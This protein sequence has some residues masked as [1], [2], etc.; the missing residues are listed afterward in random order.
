MH[1]NV[2]VW[3]KN[4]SPIPKHL[5]GEE[6]H[7]IYNGLGYRV[8]NEWVIE[9]NAYGY[10]NN[11]ITPPSPRVD[12]VVV[13][14][15]HTNST[16]QGHINPTG[17][18]HT[19]GGTTGG[20]TP[21]IPGHMIVVHKEYVLDY[22]SPLKNV[23]IEAEHEDGILT[24]R[25]VYALEKEHVVITGMQNG[26]SAI[27]P[28]P[29]TDILKLYYHT[30]RLGSVDYM[31]D[32]IA[33]DIRGYV[34]YDDWGGLTAKTV[35]TSGGHRELFDL[36][37]QYT[38]HPYDQVLDLYFAQARMYDA[39]DRRFTAVDPVKGNI[40]APPSLNL[41]VYVWD[42]P[43]IFVD[44]FG[45]TPQRV[46]GATI[47]VTF[48]G[49]T[50]AINEVYAKNNIVY[51]DFFQALSAYGIT[52]VSREM[53][54]T[55]YNNNNK[56]TFTFDHVNNRASYDVIPGGVHGV[57]NN[58][59][60]TGEFYRYNYWWDSNVHE[61]HLVTLDYFR[62]LMCDIGI[63]SGISSLALYNPNRVEKLTTKE[64]YAIANGAGNIKLI[65]LNTKKSLFINGSFS[66]WGAH[67][68][69]S[70]KTEGGVAVVIN[71]LRATYGS[72]GDDVSVL[73]SSSAWDPRP[74]I[75]EVNGYRIA[76]GFHLR[77]HGIYVGGYTPPAPL[78][79]PPEGNGD[80]GKEPLGG[81]TLG[82]HMCMYYGDNKNRSAP[83]Y[84]DV[85][86][87]ALEMVNLIF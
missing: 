84:N 63:H 71:I 51:V 39:L 43:L 52:D 16:G 29:N 32:N 7:Y 59:G 37:L 27:L 79:N 23:L 14:D 49:L 15:R 36:V 58:L 17:K 20:T 8:A 47:D 45:F 85:V 80:N 1:I 69:W 50:K 83:K 55:I 64:V 70:P 5:N 56:A 31:T 67:T 18:G 33:G 68:D 19:T 87:K 57:W 53:S 13:C 86:D 77:P 24:Y 54:G 75:L 73:M 65:D 21:T 22:T 42:N 6:S 61:R 74:G 25:Y 4:Y 62:Q 44:L 78:K 12:G 26:G 3:S 40:A 66:K 2:C 81:W 60:V 35:L 82:A 11:S 72:S 9:K 46:I 38:V 10:T 28:D 76:V 34:T 41:Y 30:D 48:G